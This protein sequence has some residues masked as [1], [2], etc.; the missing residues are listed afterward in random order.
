[1]VETERRG[2]A[3]AA[4]RKRELKL[5]GLPV[6]SRGAGKSAEKG[7]SGVQN[8]NNSKSTK[9]KGGQS[10][11]LHKGKK[12]KAGDRNARKGAEKA[13]MLGKVEKTGV[14][15]AS[16]ALPAWGGKASSLPITIGNHEEDDAEALARAGIPADHPLATGKLKHGG[17]E[18]SAEEE[19][20]VI[21]VTFTEAGALGV[22]FAPNNDTGKVE[23]LLL[24]PDTQAMDHP[25]LEPGL[26]IH[27]VQG[28]SAEGKEHAEVVGMIKAGG[29]PLEMSFVLGGTL[30]AEVQA[31]QDAIQT[32]Q[33]KVHGPNPLRG[34]ISKPGSW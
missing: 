23:V 30:A 27:G 14:E 8:S 13:A 1:M 24:H 12:H 20:E 11:A 29:R 17:A 4:A 15:R 34:L 7:R 21:S 10:K 26:V 19:D 31:E 28:V 3:K 6:M 2:S 22:K 33:E 5:A 25:D 9:R 32:V 18:D 16:T